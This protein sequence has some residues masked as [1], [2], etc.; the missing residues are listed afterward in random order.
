MCLYN[1][2]PGIAQQYFTVLIRYC[3]V[4]A[5]LYTCGMLLLHLNHHKVPGQQMVTG[6]GQ[7]DKLISF[8]NL[9]QGQN[10]SEVG[11]L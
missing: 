10:L 3:L 2:K 7:D 1:C 9:I 8:P 4:P 5:F 11:F 6:S